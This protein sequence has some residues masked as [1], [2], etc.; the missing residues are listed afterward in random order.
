M[1]P[2]RPP[3]RLFRS[4]LCSSL[5]SGRMQGRYSCVQGPAVLDVGA[6]CPGDKTMKCQLQMVGGEGRKQCGRREWGG[7]GRGPRKVQ[8]GE[9]GR[10]HRG[11]PDRSACSSALPTGPEAGGLSSS[12]SCCSSRSGLCPLRR[13]PASSFL[14]RKLLPPGGSQ[15]LPGNLSRGLQ[16]TGTLWCHIPSQFSSLEQC[17]TSW[18]GFLAPVGC[19]PSSVP[20]LQRPQWDWPPQEGGRCIWTTQAF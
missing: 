7:G 16:Q 4:T 17:I 8:Q 3:D 1:A 2:S 20:S 11:H 12:W 18:W 6:T 13:R 15:A 19:P 10:E 5:P 9:E 14:S